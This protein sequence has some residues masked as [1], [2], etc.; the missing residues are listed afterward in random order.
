[1]KDIDIMKHHEPIL[2][3]E[4]DD[5]DVMTVSESNLRMKRL[6]P[7]DDGTR[8]PISVLLIE[9]DL[10]D[11]MALI[12]AVQEQG[13]PYRLTV[14]RSVIQARAAL[15]AQSFDIV[16]SDYHLGDGTAFDLM[17]AFDEQV[18]VLLTGAGDEEVAVRAMRMGV[19]DYLVKDINR[20]YLKLMPWRVEA[21]LR[22]RQQARQMRESDEM[23]RAVIVASPVPMALNDEALRITFLN[24]AF[25]QAFGYTLQDI[26]D[27]AHWWQAAYPDPEYRQSVLEMWATAMEKATQAGVSVEPVEAKINCKD[28]STK[29]AMVSAAHL[30]KSFSGIHLVVL[31]DISE[32]KLTEDH[33]KA[34]LRDKTALLKEVHHRV[35]NNLQVINSLLRL[36][37]ARSAQPD[38]KNVLGEMQGRIRSMALLHESLYRAGSFAQVDL[39]AYV[40][41]LSQQAFRS[42]AGA[43][44]GVRLSLDLASVAVSLDQATTAGL[45]VNELISNCLKHAFPDGADGVVAVTLMRHNE[46]QWRLSVS[47]TGVGL[48]V[49]FDVRRAQS[50]GLQL[51]NDLAMQMDG[52]LHIEAPANGQHGAA[53]SVIFTSKIG[54]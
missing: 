9:D 23:F 45:L 6:D 53:F 28:G 11:E 35:K 10:I 38:T 49:D 17:D 5:V 3:V 26:P 19:Q 21:A 32:R 50:L 36:E 52:A 43:G 48:A 24:P 42:S 41:Q 30:T 40:K 1:M 12:K 31:H 51:V 18:V 13:L 4:N 14:A 46:S 8:S 54:V 29:F 2:L 44:E 39:G 22:Q 27:L 33:L 16:L 37:A 15:A 47:D 25:V 20:S 7:A 34:A